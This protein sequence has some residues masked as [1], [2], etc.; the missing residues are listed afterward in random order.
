MYRERYE[1][2]LMLLATLWY[3][4]AGRLGDLT[5]PVVR[6]YVDAVVTV[7]EAEIVAAMRL[8]YERMKLVVEPSGAVGLAA[9]L[10]PAF[11]S[12]A[13]G[14]ENIGVILCGGNV[15]LGA[16]GFWDSWL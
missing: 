13:S 6:D 5:W 14:C 4:C 1:C 10:S 3:V 12:A 9:T 15:D 7:S 11:G 8:V 16:K 2:G